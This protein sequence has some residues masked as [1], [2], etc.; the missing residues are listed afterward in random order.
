MNCPRCN[1]RVAFVKDRCDNCGQNLKN[2]RRIVSLSNICYNQGLNQA[3][4]RD[5]SGAIYSLKQS[6]E[7]YKL[8]TNARNLLGLIYFEVGEVVSALSEWVISKHFQPKNNDADKYIQ[9]IQADPNKLEVYNQTIK[10][11]NSALFSAQHGDGDMAIIQLKK[12]VS[13]NPKFIRAHQLLALL[14]MMT[15]KKDNRVRAKRLLNNISKIDV[16]NTTTIKYLKELSDIHLRGE[17]AVPKKVT[18]T[19][20]AEQRKTLPRVETDAYKPITPYKEEKPSILPFVNVIVGVL[21]GMA[22][23]GFLIMPHINSTKSQKAN[24]EFKKYSE[25]KAASDSDVSTLKA[26]N[27]KLQD[28]LDKVK[29]E[30]EELQGGS[31]EGGATMQESY[32][33]LI[34]AIQS[35]QK[36]DNEKAAK[37]LAKVNSNILESSDAKETYKKIKEETFP[38]VSETYFEQGRDAYNGQGDYAGHRD[39]DKAV[40]LLEKALEY[41]EK[42][43]DAMYFLGRCY[44]QQSDSEKAKEYYNK[45][46]NDYPQSKR[47]SEAQRRLRELG[48]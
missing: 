24:S 45:I 41:D 6:L 40:S 47:V 18:E 23:M 37:A 15:E 21:I 12:V 8:N 9:M 28:E 34:S 27:E 5:L 31:G 13:L 4:V 39:Y 20:A 35:Y 17:G 11:Y 7:F 43:T 14:Y 1:V 38:A 26:E 25:Q 33:Y 2:H 3:K 10:K 36:K 32:E 22:L 19:P 29:K 42:N 46:I 30:N 44:Q 48:E 16:T